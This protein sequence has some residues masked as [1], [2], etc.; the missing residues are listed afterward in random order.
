MTG[1]GSM[2]KRAR[3]PWIVHF[4]LAAPTLLSWTICTQTPVVQSACGEAPVKTPLSRPFQNSENQAGSCT[5]PVLAHV[6]VHMV[7]A[8]GLSGHICVWKLVWNLQD[9]LHAPQPAAGLHMD[10]NSQPTLMFFVCH[11]AA[12]C[13]AS[14]SVFRILWRACPNCVLLLY[15][16]RL[17]SSLRA[18]SVSISPHKFISVN[19]GTERTWFLIS[20]R[21]FGP[22]RGSYRTLFSYLLHL[23]VTLLLNECVSFL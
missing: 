16:S 20:P 6:W 23:H 3:C 2:R 5:N 17:Y 22:L 21:C 9:I 19:P 10:S 11:V 8:T 4:L 1:G 7:R 18:S 15:L 14:F 13:I 12:P